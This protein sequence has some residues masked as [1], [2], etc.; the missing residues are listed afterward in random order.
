MK[1]IFISVGEISGDTYASY[2]VERLKK[3]FYFTGIVGPKL[4]KL[5]IDHIS[6]IDDISVVGLVEA[7]SK[8]RKVRDVFKRSVRELQHCDVLIAVDFPGF[9]IRLI[10]EAKKLGKKV[11]YFI[12]P[13]IWAWGY[14]RIYKIIKN[15]DLMISILPFEKQYYEPFVSDRFKFLYAG[16]P[17]VD[18]VKSKTE[19]SDFEKKVDCEKN[20][21]FIGLLPGS[22]KSE[23]ETL[24]PIILESAE[25]LSRV[26]ERSYFLIPVTPNVYETVKRISSKF[27]HVPHRI[28]TQ[29]DFENPSYEV[30]RHS[31]FSV[32][33]SGTATLE[34]SIIGNPFILIYKVNPFT[35]FV[36]KR[37]V[38]IPFLGLPNIIAQK[39]IV[40]ELLQ[41][42]CNP[43]N[44]ANHAISYILRKD[45]YDNTKKQLLM[46]KEELGGEGAI[47]KIVES[48][49]EFLT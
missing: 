38:K 16:H 6:T 29:D 2:L 9:N 48:V 40:D 20:R 4:K 43:I 7:I 34:A 45:I 24:M 33:A 13:Q 17:L 31:Y 15:T 47:N 23:V 27:H 5:N 49:R 44:I 11:I 1:K 30:M 25:L 22:R 32:I 42:D 28:I 41:D 14:K 26:L 46:V 19:R 35:F 8:Y 36:G 18:I 10:Q 3:D 12:S 21:V 37:L 39:P